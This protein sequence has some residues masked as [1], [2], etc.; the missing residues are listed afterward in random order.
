MDILKTPVHANLFIYR[1]A[2]AVS[3]NIRMLDIDQCPD[4]YWVPN[5]FK[6]THK[7]DDKTSYVSPS[8]K[9]FQH[10]AVPTFLSILFSVFQFWDGGSRPEATSVSANKGTSTLSKIPSLTTTVNWLKPNS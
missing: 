10:K 8:I 2:V 7:C 3:M 9:C 1:G 4:R 5:A 6:D